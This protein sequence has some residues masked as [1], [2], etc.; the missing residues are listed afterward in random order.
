M[1]SN[2]D[3]EKILDISYDGPTSPDLNAQFDVM[4]DVLG[5]K[6][7]S[8]ED[9]NGIHVRKYFFEDKESKEDF[10]EMSHIIISKH[11]RMEPISL[12]EMVGQLYWTSAEAV[13]HHASFENE[14]EARRFATMLRA[15]F[16]AYLSSDMF[17]I[18]FVKTDEKEDPYF[19]IWAFPNESI[20]E[21]S[22][23]NDDNE[24]D[25]MKWNGVLA[26]D[27]LNKKKGDLN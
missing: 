9:N 6:F 25:L 21:I 17:D 14:N 19:I 20:L 3:S 7:I 18:I 4:C 27:P 2:I 13:Y 12:D 24:G 26:I 11:F 15:T 5:G 22:E 23:T 16:S 1:S 10:Y 8:A